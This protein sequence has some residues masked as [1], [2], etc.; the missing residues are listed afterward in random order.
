MHALPVA[1]SPLRA[2]LVGVTLAAFGGTPASA[3]ALY[4]VDPHPRIATGRVPLTE[5]FARRAVLVPSYSR[6]THLSCD[7]CHFQFPQLTPFG[8][9]FKL[10]GYTLTGL[11]TVKN[12]HDSTHRENLSLAP[13]SPLSAMIV[14]S[15]SHVAKPLPGTQ[16]N[17]A[18]L[19]QQASIFLGGALTP[20]IG[21]FAQFTYSAAEGH[22]GIDNFDV[23]YATHVDLKGHDLLFGATLHNNPTTQDVF[24][25]ASAWSWPFI[26]SASGPSPSA[27]TLLQGA[28]SQRVAG[29]GA[30]G[31]WD[32]VVYAEFTMYRSAQQ[33]TPQ[34]P[35]STSSGILQHVAPYGR[36]VVTHDV[37]DGHISIGAFGMAAQLYSAGASGPTDRYTD[38]GTDLQYESK[39]NGDHVFIVRSSFTH[40]RRRSDADVL[41]EIATQPTR[42]LN[43]YRVSA[44]YMP[45]ASFNYTLGGFITSGTSDTLAF[46]PA[47]V[48]G[49]RT[50]SPNSSGLIGEVVVNPWQNVRFG[51][52]YT[53]FFRFNGSATRYDGVGRNASDNNMFFLYSWIAF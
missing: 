45:S 27:S 29:L 26:A 14:T 46:A 15:I 3:R 17:N 37:R 41:A 47:P 31:L 22:I 12:V 42:S 49:S 8:R 19:P 44:S 5:A 52:Q 2:I 7:V 36:V 25:T 18:S 34:V 35:D 24:N 39:V 43:D 51:L 10:N 33:G 28:L 53:N 48:S 23:R 40:E 6:Q 50:G 32:N 16:N 30:Y 21:A 11:T 9:Q 20:K 38:V 1:S 4:R 13:I